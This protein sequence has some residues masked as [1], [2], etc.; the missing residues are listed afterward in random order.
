MRKGSKRCVKSFET[1][2]VIGKDLEAICVFSK[3]VILCVDCTHT[4]WSIL[5]PCRVPLCVCVLIKVERYDIDKG[6]EMIFDHLGI[7][8]MCDW[9]ALLCESRMSLL[10]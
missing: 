6:G 4:W 2:C 3:L 7:S 9:C 10:S 5:T 1:L 8:S